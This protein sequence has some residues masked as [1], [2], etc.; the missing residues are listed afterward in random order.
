MDL[1]GRAVL[2]HPARVARREIQVDDPGVQRMGRID[3]PVDDA[4]DPL[5][6]PGLSEALPV[7]RRRFDHLQIDSGDLGDAV[8]GQSK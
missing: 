1:D 7:Q 2:D 6:L 4:P 5:V 8:L 3:F